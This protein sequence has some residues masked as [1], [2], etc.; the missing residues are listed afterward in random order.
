MFTVISKEIIKVLILIIF[1]IIILFPLYYLLLIALKND[2]DIDNNVITISIKKPTLSSFQNVWNKELLKAFGITVSAIF[3]LLILRIVV[4]SLAIAGLIKLKKKSIQNFIIYFLIAI[5]V[6]PEFVLYSALKYNL[7]TWNLTNKYWL[8]L[9]TN[10]IFSFFIFSYTFKVALN[11]SQTK[12]RLALNDN[13]K[14]YEKIFYVY[15]S[16][17]KLSYLLLIIFT[18]IQVW[19]DFLW[20]LYLFRGSSDKNISQWFLFPVPK[21]YT[22]IHNN[23]IAAGSFIASVIPLSIYLVFSKWVNKS[24]R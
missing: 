17:L 10:G 18:T 13:L 3:S 9:I 5:S 16:D 8:S 12:G 1:A 11:V 21:G 19:N 22:N 2:I 14:W 23:I 15:F 20:P 6:I 4:Y 7:N 24:T